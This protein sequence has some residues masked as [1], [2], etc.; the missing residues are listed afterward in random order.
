MKQLLLLFSLLLCSAA[1]FAVIFSGAQVPETTST[2]PKPDESPLFV[3]RYAELQPNERIAIQ[4]Y[5]RCNRGVV[6]ID[7]R[8]IHNA[9]LFGQIPVGQ[10]DEPGAGSGIVLDKEGYILTNYHVIANVDVIKVTLFNGESYEAKRV[11]I[12]PIT[13]LAVVMIKAPKDVLFPLEPGDSSKLLVG[14]QIFAIGNPY[15][16]ERTL[17]SG[18]ISSLNRSIPGKENRNI[19]GLIQTDAA[20][21]PGNSG[22][23]LLD[24]QGKLIGINTAIVGKSGGSHGIGF[25]IP[26]RTIY[27]IVP[28][29]ITDGKVIRAEAG[30]EIAREVR[31]TLNGVLVQGL[32]IVRLAEKGAAEKAGLRGPRF[33]R[34]RG[35]LQPQP[36]MSVADIIT[37]VEGIPVKKGD[38]FL[39]IIDERKPG[40]R[41]VLDVFREGRI[42]KVPIT[43]D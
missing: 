9:L 6:N 1:F 30:I 8:T 31:E 23:A 3:E 16:L 42:I 18:L 37:A 13:D 28:H 2:L 34:V 17:T 41:I 10:F 11:G 7:T 25:A 12:D 32:L 14:Q 36:D 33:V 5:Q 39:A 4:V 19:T 43:L 35:A 38:D 20:I 29:L 26:T 40:D 24:T 27:R 15:G 21:N 22:G